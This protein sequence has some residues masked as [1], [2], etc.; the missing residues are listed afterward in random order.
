MGLARLRQRIVCSWTWRRSG[1]NKQV[2]EIQ[3]KVY[4]QLKMHGLVMWVIVDM[5]V[6]LKVM[7]V[8][9]RAV[10]GLEMNQTLADGN[11][12]RGDGTSL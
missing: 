5:L 8:R 9:R 12:V 1:R 4:K 11:N 6:T 10:I 3:W 7:N 2:T